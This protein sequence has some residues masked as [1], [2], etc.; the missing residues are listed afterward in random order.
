MTD[1]IAVLSPTDRVTDQNGVPISGAKLNFF[2]AGTSTP[3]VVYSDKDL[4][5]PLGP[6]VYCDSG[7]YPVTNDGGTTKTAIF[8]GLGNFKIQIADADDVTYIPIDNLPGALDTSEFNPGT[9]NQQ[10]PVVAKSSSFTIDEDTDNGILFD[11]NCTG[12]DATAT[13]PSA[14]DAGDGFYCGVRHNG[15]A[16]EV[17][18]ETA[19]SQL[20]R[21]FGAATDAIPLTGRGE[22]VWLASDGANWAV[23]SYCPA[24]INNTPGILTIADRFSAP[25]VSPAAGAR[26]ILTSSPSGAWSSF[27]EHDIVESDGSGSWIRRT[28]PTDCG[29]VGYVQDEDTYYRFIGSAWVAENAT[30]TIKGTVKVSTQAIMETGT[31]TDAVP[32]I[33]H[34]HF[35][36]RVAKA[37]GYADVSGNLLAN[38][39]IGSVTDNGSGSIT[40]TFGTTMSST[41]YGVVS[42]LETNTSQQ[43]TCHLTNRAAGSIRLTCRDTSGNL[44]DPNAWNM[45]VFG[46]T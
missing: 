9:V 20:I 4:S 33:G 10:V 28:P 11:V 35:H 29:W 18:I 12:G 41:N 25:P 22:T 17:I 6:T 31:A 37:W 27:S 2:E 45:A 13:F 44:D 26:Y 46:D 21:H 38:A 8:T 7:G 43:R 23:Y 32:L 39:G 16:N 5:V 19:S 36:P 15:T 1:S 42:G 24:R 30:S 34:L 3:R 14:I 40:F